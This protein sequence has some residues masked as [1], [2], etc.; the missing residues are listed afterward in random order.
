MRVVSGETRTGLTAS[1]LALAA[2]GTVTLEAMLCKTPMV[3][4]YRLAGSTYQ[5]AR[6]LRLVKSRWISLPNVLAGS[7][8][9]PER[10][11]HEANA[12]R[13]VADARAW[14][15]DDSRQRSFTA[16][17]EQIHRRLACGAASNAAK[18]ILREV[19]Y[20]RDESLGKR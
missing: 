15:E 2:S 10:I 3:V 13:L 9:V 19:G 1:D 14:L 6:A 8:L 17:A 20:S 4:F 5:L 7:D 18:A 11:Q 12:D 16:T